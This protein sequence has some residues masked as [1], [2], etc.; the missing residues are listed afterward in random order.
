[1]CFKIYESIQLLT[2][3]TY[4]IRPSCANRGERGVR[5][6]DPLSQENSNVLNIHS[7]ITKDIPRTPYNRL[8]Y[9]SDPTPSLR[10]IFL[11]PRMTIIMVN[12]LSVTSSTGRMG[13]RRGQ[14]TSLS[15]P[16]E[17]EFLAFLPCTV[18]TSIGQTDIVF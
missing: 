18:N 4:Y 13:G 7:K 9:P 1:M 12:L 16:G 3:S 15:S 14:L 5:G 2:I 10:K 17:T 11:D 8:N 6:P